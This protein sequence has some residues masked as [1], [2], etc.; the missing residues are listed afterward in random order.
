MKITLDL[1]DTDLAAMQ[2]LRK[3][4]IAWL[5][6]TE[7]SYEVNLAAIKALQKAASKFAWK[8]LYKVEAEVELTEQ[9]G[10]YENG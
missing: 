3:R 4:D 1:D 5:E 7:K 2:D 10:D 6:S 9:R 8:M